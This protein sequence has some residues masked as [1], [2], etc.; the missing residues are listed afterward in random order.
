MR[1]CPFCS[2]LFQDANWRCPACRRSPK[3]D[4]GFAILAPELAEGGGGFRPEYFSQLAELEAGSFWFRERN[5]LLI[6]ALRRYFPAIRHYLEIGCGTGYVLSGVAQAYPEAILT[7]SEV[8]S[9]GLP[10]AAKRVERATLLQMDARNIPYADEFDVIGAFDVLEHIEEDEQVLAEM[11][12]ALRPGGGIALTV[13]QHPW[14]WS[15]QD[16]R[17]CHVRRYRLGELRGK[18]A[19]AG[20]QVLLETS[21]VSLLLPTMIASRKLQGRSPSEEEAL[22]ELRLPRLIN[23]LFEGIMNAERQLIRA[24]VRFPVGGSLLLLAKKPEA[25]P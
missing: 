9:V 6:W 3:Q 18:V 11:R 2:T 25:R 5:R 14:L 17:A 15:R 8:F 12:R 20:F 16:D 19:R 21:F 1:R 4:S 24:G 23:S 22:A 10:Y 7:G 13:P